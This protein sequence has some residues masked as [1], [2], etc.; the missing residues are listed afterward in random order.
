MMQRN[1]GPRI[2]SGVESK[3]VPDSLVCAPFSLCAWGIRG[4]QVPL[5]AERAVAQER[6]A[7]RV[8]DVSCQA[9]VPMMRGKNGTQSVVIRVVAAF[10]VGMHFVDRL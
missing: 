1:R 2:I 3:V 6:M 8:E 10:S 7:E 4:V 9:R 5:L